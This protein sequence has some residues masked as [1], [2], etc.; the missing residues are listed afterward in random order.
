LKSIGIE[1][2]DHT[3]DFIPIG[4]L[5]QVLSCTSAQRNALLHARTV[6]GKAHLAARDEL[7]NR[8]HNSAIGTEKLVRTLEWISDEALIII[9]LDLDKVGQLLKEDVR[10]RNQFETKDSG[11]LLDE[12]Q[13]GDWER[14]L[15]GAAY[16]NASPPERCKYGVMDVMND[17]KGVLVA[18]QYGDSYMVLKNMRMCCS[19]TSRDSGNF[20]AAQFEDQGMAA[21]GMPDQYAHILQ[22][23]E[24]QE[25]VEVVRVANMTSKDKKWMGDSKEIHGMRYK[26]VQIHSKIDLKRNVDRLVAHPKHRVDGFPLDSILGLCKEHGWEFVWMDDEEDVRRKNDSM[27]KLTLQSVPFRRPSQSRSMLH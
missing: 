8:F 6:A 12:G 26:E 9:H 10:Y 27:K 20:L 5:F 4:E 15:F 22:Q 24:D 17:K 25:L 1:N 11:G 23:Y 3:W 21:L 16:D 14:D 18:R 19:C 7:V 2:P 13:R